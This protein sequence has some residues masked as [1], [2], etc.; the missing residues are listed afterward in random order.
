MSPILGAGSV[1]RFHSKDEMD[2]PWA[3][4]FL[5][6][7]TTPGVPS[8]AGAADPSFAARVSEITQAVL[9]K[10][11]SI[12]MLKSLSQD[13]VSARVPTRQSDGGKACQQGQPRLF[14][15][16]PTFLRV[17]DH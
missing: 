15:K 5:G 6:E 7:P 16:I 3:V 1:V 14:V 11:Q 8:V 2:I 13:R 9:E 10:N 17:A 12:R 4:D